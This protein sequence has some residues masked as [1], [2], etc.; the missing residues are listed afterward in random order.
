MGNLGEPLGGAGLRA[1]EDGDPLP[2]VVAGLLVVVLP[3][4]LRQLR[5]GRG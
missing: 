2:A 1:E 5:P 4:L 3:G